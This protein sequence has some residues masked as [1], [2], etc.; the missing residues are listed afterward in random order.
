[1]P[2]FSDLKRYCERTGWVLIRTTDHFYYEKVLPS[3]VVLRTKVSM[4]LGSEIPAN[5]WQS[6]LKKQLQTTQ[7]EFNRN[8]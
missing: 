2:G 4:S 1:M 8:S 5:L 7:E 3:G 6:I